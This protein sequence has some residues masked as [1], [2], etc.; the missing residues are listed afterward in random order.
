LAAHRTRCHLGRHPGRVEVLDSPLNF[1]LDGLF[2]RQYVG[3]GISP[4]ASRGPGRTDRGG[5]TQ[6][7]PGDVILQVQLVG[8]DDL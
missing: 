4:L 7:A 5:P 1:P 8:T 3:G 2:G 6:P